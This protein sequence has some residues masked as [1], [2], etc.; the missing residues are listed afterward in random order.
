[1]CLAMCLKKQE[2]QADCDYKHCVY[3]KKVC[4]WQEERELKEIKMKRELGRIK[5]MINNTTNR[6]EKNP[7]WTYEPSEKLDIIL[8]HFLLRLLRLIT[9]GILTLSIIVS[10]T[11]FP[12]GVLSLIARCSSS[13]FHS[14]PL[15]LSPSFFP[16]FPDKW[17]IISNL[18]LLPRK[19]HHVTQY[20]VMYYFVWAYPS[21]CRQLLGFRVLF[22]WVSK[23]AHQ[24][25][26]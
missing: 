20:F 7:R 23:R 24:R 6:W 2:F 22:I 17:Y 8:C 19:K 10:T 25:R 1:M 18:S 21:V 5:Y 14:P 9:P 13:F 11:Y 16:Y 12:S 3:K 26:F 4:Y 15:T